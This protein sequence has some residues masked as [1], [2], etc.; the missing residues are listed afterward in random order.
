MEALISRFHTERQAPVLVDPLN[1]FADGQPRPNAQYVVA[2]MILRAPNYSPE[3]AIRSREGR[4][5]RKAR[6]T[7]SNPLLQ[8]ALRVVSSL[9]GC[10]LVLDHCALGS[11]TY[12]KVTFLTKQ[13]ISASMSS[14][15]NTKP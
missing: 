3:R 12:P 2:K 11:C 5:V 9:S 14:E 6:F 1:P 7:S 8:A 15:T 10:T 4:A 13:R